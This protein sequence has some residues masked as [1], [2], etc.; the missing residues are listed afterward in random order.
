[1]DKRERIIQAAIDV[2]SEKGIEKATISEIVN[3]AG[4][5]QGTFYLY[6]TS[7]LAVMPAIAEVMVNKILEGITSEVKDG[8]ISQQIEVIIRVIFNITNEYKELT[9]LI[10]TGL[11]Q[12]QYV[13]NWETIYAPL[14]RWI[15]D[16]LQKGKEAQAIHPD[17]NIK[18]TAKILIG[19][20]ESVAE[21]VYLYD[22][23]DAESIAGHKKELHKF[24]TNALRAYQ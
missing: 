22:H 18:Y 20:I 14:Y 24:V 23:L 6:F 17:V 1:M 5:A 21:Q 12:T 16:L 7:K 8:P 11:T 10:Y 4:I 3:K 9:K 19:S 2:F 15:E 13:G